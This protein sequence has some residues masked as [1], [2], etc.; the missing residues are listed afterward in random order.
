MIPSRDADTFG[1][2]YFY[3]DL[4]DKLPNPGNILEDAWGVEIFYNIEVTPW[5]HITPD[6]QVIN[7]SVKSRDKAVIG[8]LRVKTVF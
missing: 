2:G 1:I 4:S 6:F 8:G 5:L 3:I 7:T